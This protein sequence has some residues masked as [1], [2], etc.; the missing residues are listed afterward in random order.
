ME[1]DPVIY[2]SKELLACAEH[3]KSHSKKF[4]MA[5]AAKLMCQ[6]SDALDGIRELVRQGN[7]PIALIRQKLTFR[8][9]EI[10]LNPH[11][12]RRPEIE[13]LQRSE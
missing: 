5:W 11:L 4:L 8:Q 10:I 3:E 6:E 7:I 1:E 9:A 13:E 12:V 2:I